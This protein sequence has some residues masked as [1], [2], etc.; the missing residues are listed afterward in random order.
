MGLGGVGVLGGGVHTVDFEPASSRCP[1]G[2]LTL[3]EDSFSL[4]SFSFLH[5][6]HCVRGS[7]PYAKRPK[8]PGLNLCKSI[9]L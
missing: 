1:A 6:F 3:P 4:F 8:L 7:I 5:F 2:C 9:C